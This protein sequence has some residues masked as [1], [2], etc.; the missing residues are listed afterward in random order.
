MV[1]H[2]LTKNDRN[3]RNPADTFK[4]KWLNNGYDEARDLRR[5]RKI[6]TAVSESLIDQFRVELDTPGKQQALFSLL[7][8]KFVVKNFPRHK[9]DPKYL[10]TLDRKKKEKLLGDMKKFIDEKVTE[11]L[12]HY[13]G[14]HET[15]RK[16]HSDL[17]EIFSSDINAEIHKKLVK[18]RKIKIKNGRKGRSK[19]IELADTTPDR[20]LFVQNVLNELLESNNGVEEM[21]LRE[22]N[23]RMLILP[24]YFRFHLFERMYLNGLSKADV[25]AGM[26]EYE[27]EVKVHMNEVGIDHISE[28]SGKKQIDSAVILA[29]ERSASLKEEF[30]ADFEDGDGDGVDDRLVFFTR[31]LTLVKLVDNRYSPT[32]IFWIVKASKYFPTVGNGKAK[33]NNNNNSNSKDDLTV[34][35]SYHF[36]KFCELAMA[37]KEDVFKIAGEVYDTL[38]Q[39]ETQ[40]LIDIHNKLQEHTDSIDMSLYSLDIVDPEESV[41]QEVLKRFLKIKRV[42]IED[43]NLF[44]NLRIFLRKWISEAFVGSLSK[45]GAALVWDYLFLQHFSAKAIQDVCLAL[46][47]LLKPMLDQA[48]DYRTVSQTLIEGP[49]T[50]LTSDIRRVI[51]HFAADGLYD[52]IPGTP[53]PPRVSVIPPSARDE[54]KSM[55]RRIEALNLDFMNP[56]A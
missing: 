54:R 48:D 55:E 17:R 45:N 47:F 26:Q 46:L 13:Q 10:D 24:P 49:R 44:T 7:G 37:G 33:T 36:K 12:R 4:S 31:I 42:F 53:N 25:R 35:M 30:E 1:H 38:E 15:D 21:V 29:Y 43:Q 52:T 34:S 50:L 32:G 18:E 2:K 41:T 3:K 56:A 6:E 11:G 20:I 19:V 8:S 16:L 39:E 5:M 28:W 40:L 51:R 27:K 9:Y 14:T 23:H 22:L